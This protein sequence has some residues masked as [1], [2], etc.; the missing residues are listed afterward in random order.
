MYF[1]LV[2]QKRNTSVFKLK[3]LTITQGVKKHLKAEDERK[4]KDRPGF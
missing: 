2:T 4:S 3:A 1:C